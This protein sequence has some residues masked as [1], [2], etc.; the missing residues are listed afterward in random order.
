MNTKKEL[1]ESLVGKKLRVVSVENYIHILVSK[2]HDYQEK[3][4]E[5]GDELFKVK[6][7]N[8]IH[9]YN[10]DSFHSFTKD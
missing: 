5:V 3:I 6:S 4:I 2:Y 8:L 7:G 9:Y 1:L 10:I